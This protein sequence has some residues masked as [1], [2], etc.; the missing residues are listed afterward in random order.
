MK[1]YFH[2]KMSSS[3]GRKAYLKRRIYTILKIFLIV[4]VFS[5]YFLILLRATMASLEDGRFRANKL[6]TVA[7]PNRQQSQ[8][9]SQKQQQHIG[10]SNGRNS[11][12]N[13]DQITSSSLSLKNFKDTTTTSFTTILNKNT[14]HQL[15]TTLTK[16]KTI[17]KHIKLSSSLSTVTTAKKKNAMENNIVSSSTVN[18]IYEYSEELNTAA[19]MQF[20]ER[21]AKLWDECVKH[22][23]IGKY[24][25][26][27]WEFFISPGHGITWCNIFK[28]ASS[29]W[30]YYFNILGMKKCLL[31]F[32]FLFLFIIYIFILIQYI[33]APR[34]I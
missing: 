9:Q 11:G 14:K 8:K 6:D 25:P 16:H 31:L 29:T 32:S 18:P 23:I 33:Q 20:N 26:N 30:M 13:G 17:G 28:A 19:E 12:V 22:N 7:P 24:P 2:I 15:E 21:K 3:T 5:L 10:I 27:A 34:K 1:Y 4:I